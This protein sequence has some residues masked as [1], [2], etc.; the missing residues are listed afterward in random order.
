MT[1]EKKHGQVRREQLTAKET[2]KKPKLSKDMPAHWVR[3][4]ADANASFLTHDT[5]KNWKAGELLVGKNARE[6][7]LS[8]EA[9]GRSDILE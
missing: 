5:R 1:P 7:I 9:G 8:C 4:K 3:K 2:Q 6:W